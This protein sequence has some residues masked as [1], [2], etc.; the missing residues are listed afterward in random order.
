MSPRARGSFAG[1]RRTRRANGIAMR[2][3]ERYRRLTGWNK[4]AAWGA[5]ASIL[6]LAVTLLALFAR[7]TD[8]PEGRTVALQPSSTES[9]ARPST[10][11]TATSTGRNANSEGVEIIGHG[12]S[13]TTYSVRQ[14]DYRA[15]NGLRELSELESGRALRAMPPS[16]FGFIASFD[17]VMD[18]GE[19]Q[20]WLPALTVRRFPTPD[21]FED[22]PFEVV[23]LSGRHP[24]VLGFSTE[25]GSAV[26]AAA[27]TTKVMISARP[28]GDLTTLVL[29]PTL[30]LARLGIRLVEAGPGRR[31]FVLDVEL[32]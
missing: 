16:T 10:P 21:R 15:R 20:T 2:N 5:V 27:E 14:R 32:Q 12:Y 17:F 6:G 29:I 28:R 24:A 4:L 25:A 9:V 26:L 22:F 18:R 11:P 30:R 8:T 13:G 19:V 31:Y 1:V 7:S 23:A 3:A